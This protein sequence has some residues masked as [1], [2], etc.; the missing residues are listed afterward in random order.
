MSSFSLPPQKTARHVS[1]SVDLRSL[2]RLLGTNN[3]VNDLVNIAVKELLQNAADAVRSEEAASAD[4]AY[5]GRIKISFDP[6]QRLLRVVDNG[7]SMSADTIDNHFLRLGASLKSNLDAGQSSGGFGLAKLTFL[8]SGQTIRVASRHN[9]QRSAFEANGERLLAGRARLTTET[10]QKPNGTFIE[11]LFPETLT[12]DTGE[13]IRVPFPQATQDVR[14]LEAPMLGKAEISV[15][16]GADQPEVLPLSCYHDRRQQPWF[17]RLETE[18]ASI[19]IYR[20]P[21]PVPFRR[22]KTSVLSCGVYQFSPNLKTGHA[23]TFDVHSKV[24][25]D[26]ASYPFNKQREGWNARLACD[27]LVLQK[28]LDFRQRFEDGLI[29]QANFRRA[30][31]IVGHSKTGTYAIVPL[32]SADFTNHRLFRTPYRFSLRDHCLFLGDVP[33]Y[34]RNYGSWRETEAYHQLFNELRGTRDF[35]YPVVI[36]NIDGDVIAEAAARAGTSRREVVNV[37]GALATTFKAYFEKLAALPNFKPEAIQKVAYGLIFDKTLAGLHTTVPFYASAL[38]PCEAL[39]DSPRAWARDW[40]HTMLHENAHWVTMK[41]DATFASAMRRGNARLEDLYPGY[42]DATFVHLHTL[43]MK[44]QDVIQ[45][46]RSIQLDPDIKNRDVSVE[47]AT[48]RSLVPQ[49]ANARAVPC[50]GRKVPRFS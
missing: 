28:I 15:Q 12:D 33:L 31:Q 35:R 42:Y 3:Y 25:P 17:G 7:I 8:F 11:I 19:D 37:L 47:G 18:W 43:A 13:E 40:L 32:G 16:W 27:V 41:H 34:E 1:L 30:A 4:P 44:H 5:Y 9:G 49:R 23:V 24:D 22:D 26:S 29:L 21:E 6:A 45:A 20:T 38:N 10:T 2:V 39:G 36:N 14:V 50:K 46:L 48:A